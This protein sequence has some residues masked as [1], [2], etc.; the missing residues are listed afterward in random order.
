M[1]SSSFKRDTNLN[2]SWINATLEDSPTGFCLNV[3]SICLPKNELLVGLMSH[4]D[5]NSL[6]E[7][8]SE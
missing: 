2:E 5:Y 7:I 8:V 6:M 1:H 4:E 3:G